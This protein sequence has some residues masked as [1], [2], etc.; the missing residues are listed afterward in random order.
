MKYGSLIS[1]IVPVYNVADLLD[2]CVESVCHQTYENLEIILVDD[3]STDGSGEICDKWEAIDDR[4]VVIHK[5][6]GGISDARNAA[7]DIAKGEYI[8]FV[9]SDD[10]IEPCMYECLLRKLEHT[11]ND[12]V[13]C[14]YRTVDE[15]GNPCKQIYD[16]IP[17]CTVSAAEYIKMVNKNERNHCTLVVVWNKLF[18]RCL[19]E[20]IRFQVGVV[21]EDEFFLNEILLRVNQIEI[22]C[23]PYYNYL[24]RTGSV[25]HVQFDEKRMVYFYAIRER[26]K[27][28]DK[29]NFGTE[30]IEAVAREC[31]DSGVRFWMLAVNQKIAD[32]QKR[33]QFYA[34]V[35]EVKHKYSRYG[36]LKQRMFWSA[37]E[38]APWLLKGLYGVYKAVKKEKE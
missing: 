28:C 13:V 18:R 9:D 6:N 33:K 22:L 25:M 11:E 19:L 23:T 17:D 27:L 32:A 38:Y 3:G 36:T 29:N 4:I 34:D 37:F 1:I 2:K 8:G 20:K 14:A 12:L 5:A 24:Q 30:C 26:L 7:L 16:N 21:H 31:L 10:S 35:L 15:N